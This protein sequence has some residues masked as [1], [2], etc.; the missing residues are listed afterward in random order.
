MHQVIGLGILATAVLWA[1]AA[2]AEPGHGEKVYDP[3]VSNCL[4]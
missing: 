4:T 2:L 3:Y 1:G